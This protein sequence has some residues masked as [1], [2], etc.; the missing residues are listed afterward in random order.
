MKAC[1]YLPEFE[2]VSEQYP[3]HL[4]TGRRPLHFHTRTK[5]GRTKELQEGDPEPYLQ[6]GEKDAKALGIK[7]GNW[8]IVESKRGKIEL[9]ARVGLMAEKQVFL[10]W[11]FG[12]FDARD[13]RARAAN[14]LTQ[15]MVC[16]PNYLLVYDNAD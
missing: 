1:H 7:E 3:L 6:I 15:G 4:S 12:Y 10:P 13:G 14:E 5:T 2:S 16:K 8:V 9:Q 11:H